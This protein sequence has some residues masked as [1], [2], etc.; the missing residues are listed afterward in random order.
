MAELGGDK[1]SVVITIIELSSDVI[2]YSSCLLTIQS[3]PNI[4]LEAK[5]VWQRLI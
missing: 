3:T 5:V 1:L 2:V 4:K